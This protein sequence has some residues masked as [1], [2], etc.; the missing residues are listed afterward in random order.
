MITARDDYRKANDSLIAFVNECCIRTEGLTKTSIFNKIY[1][2]WC[3]A[4]TLC[5]E[6]LGERK[7]ILRKNFALE[8]FKT[9]GG[10]DH[11]R[12]TIKPEKI[13]ELT[14][15]FASLKELV[16]EL[17]GTEKKQKGD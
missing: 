10:H 14:D 8:A 5:I 17:E 1:E 12:L 3:T 9:N 16:S 7:N 6:A 11:F 13:V 4:N 15:M 2:F